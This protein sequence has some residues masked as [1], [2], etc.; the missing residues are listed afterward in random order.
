[1]SSTR[2]T[3]EHAHVIIKKG[4]INIKIPVSSL[5]PGR[6]SSKIDWHVLDKARGLWKHRRLDGLAFQRRIRA[7]W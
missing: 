7:E 6:Q 4:W 1:M 3:A 2:Q 5:V